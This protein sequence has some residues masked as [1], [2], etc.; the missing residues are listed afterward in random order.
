M[1]PSSFTTFGELLRYLR[2]Q[3]RLT[4]RDLGIAIGYSEGHINR[5]E[6]DKAW[7][8][9]TLVAALIVPALHLEQESSLARRLL[10]LAQIR[11]ACPASEPGPAPVPIDLTEAIPPAP[12]NEIVRSLTLYRLAARLSTER[13]ILLSGLAGVG[14]TCLAA[15]LARQQAACMPVFWLTLTG[16]VTTSVDFLIYQLSLFLAGHGHPHIKSLLQTAPNQPHP[17]LD[18]SLML[19]SNALNA[20]PVLLCFD[21]AETIA[22]N[23]DFL[24][25]LQHLCATTTAGMVFTS[26]ETLPL[27]GIF[28]IGLTGL[29][30]TE[31]LTLISSLSDGQ[32]DP[33]QALHLLEKTNGNPMLI[34]LAVAQLVVGQENAARFIEDLGAQPQVASFLLETV[35]NQASPT[36]WRLLCLLA[37]FLQS[38]N[39]Y[40]GCLL[41]LIQGLDLAQ[42]VGEAI[43]SLQN[44]HLVDDPAHAVLNPLV[45]E[46]VYRS[47]SVDSTH[48]R[49]LHR[50]AGDWYTE[51]GQAGLSAAQ[52]YA[53][54]GLLEETVESIARNELEIIAKGQA[55]A[56]VTILDEILGAHS[57]IHALNDDLLRRLLVTRGDLLTPTIR[58]NEA[59]EN[60]RQALALANNPAVRAD[61]V[62]HMRSAM[63]TRGLF[64]EA[65]ERIQAAQADLSPADQLLNAQ[66]CIFKSGVNVVLGKL[67]EAHQ[68]AEQAIA[69]A[70]QLEHISILSAETIRSDAYY[71]L[72]NIARHASQPNVAIEHARRA[73]ASARH[74]G[75]KIR[76]TACQAFIG[77]MLFDAGD[78]QGS[79]QYRQEA[80]AGAQAIGDDMGVALYSTNLVDIEHLQLHLRAAAE[81]LEQAESFFEYIGDTRSLAFTLN[82]RATNALLRG[83]IV[84]ASA[85][86]NRVINAMEGPATKLW[87]GDVLEKLAMVHL[88][89]GQTALAKTTLQRALAMTD[90]S[91]NA[92]SKFRL[93]TNLALAQ[94]IEGEV[95]VARQTLLAAPRFDGL[96]LW[97]L[98]DRDAV[99]CCVLIAAGEMEQA[100]SLAAQ[101]GQ[102][103]H[104]CPYYQ[105]IGLRLENTIQNNLPVSTFP[106]LLWLGDS[107]ISFT[108]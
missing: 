88:V 108:N 13:R 102:H 77:G 15:A 55:P 70:D 92:M 52:H 81:K 51:T 64:T 32:I 14:K 29:D 100:A 23:T 6:K 24:Q 25:V 39:L 75:M 106:G 22:R 71:Y 53:A 95:P 10:E 65:L 78:L 90:V 19:I 38:V 101:I 11:P 56:A 62:F 73:L 8:D 76:E 30:R 105:R 28:E 84:Q 4:Q 43:A 35:Q 87:W 98:L 37:V 104:A 16:G 79:L 63:L 50:L 74:S 82:L 2:R 68:P 21:N 59:I 97:T 27:K 40:D 20:Q 44:R 46:Y 49:R 31:G 12:S 17:P 54:A 93:N 99:D 94:A 36:E 33:E 9:P 91:N 85:M 66:L 45:Q 103:S 26:R 42:P 41:E 3:S 61:I 96:S 47:M 7:P 34:R 18:R 67:N 86:I 107:S 80:L 89:Q 58:A 72:A 48:R 57:K 69:L 83:D 1:D 5:Y 60:F